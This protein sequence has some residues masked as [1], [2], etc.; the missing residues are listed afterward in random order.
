MEVRLLTGGRSGGGGAGGGKAKGG[1]GSAAPRY[2]QQEQLDEAAQK[3]SASVSGWLLRL[4]A[5]VLLPD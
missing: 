2:I 1:R 5:Q 4:S 3:L